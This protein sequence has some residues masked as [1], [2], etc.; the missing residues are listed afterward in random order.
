MTF[1]VLGP[2]EVRRDGE[3]VEIAGQ[4][5]RTLLGLLVLDAGRIVP[6]ER[7][8]AGI[9]DDQVP[10]GVGNALQALISRLRSALGK[11][12]ARG[13]VVGE[14]AGYR[15]V[16]G[17]DQVDVRRFTLLAR[18]GQEALAA[19]DASTAA[20]TLRE[21]LALWRGPVLAGL[22]GEVIAADVARLESR[23]LSVAEDRIEAELRLGRPAGLIDELS[24]LLAAHPLRERLHGQRMRA[25]Y[26]AG[27]RVEALAAY[28][29]A[30]RTFRDELGADPSPALA[31]LHLTMLRG[32]P[33]TTDNG[34][35]PP[36]AE[37]GSG[38]PTPGTRRSSAPGG[39]RKGRT[40]DGPSQVSV[41][42]G[43]MPD[44]GPEVGGRGGREPDGR[45]EGWG[46]EGRAPEGVPPAGGRR[47]NLR[48][49]LTSFVG[50]EADLDHTAG[51]LSAHRLVTLIGP[52]G[53]GKTRLATEVAE[54]VTESMPDGV[55]LAELAPVSD[56]AGLVQSLL[57]ALDLRDGRSLPM[58][59]LPQDPFER[60]IRALRGKRLLIVLDNCEHVVEQA[61][62]IAD[63]VLADCPGVR[64]L[65]TSREPLGITGEV[66]W[67]LPPLG[68]PPA[69]VDPGDAAGYPAVRLFADRAAAVRPG[70][71]V[72]QDAGPVV[73]ICRAL[74][75]LPLAIE[76]AAARLRSL[77]A[78][79]IAARLG[80]R[81]G[82]FRLL[83]SGSRTAQARHQTLRAVV[84]WSWNL[85]DE[86]ERALGRR[87][88]VFAGGA[89]LD[90]I[91]RV[92]AA[93]VERLKGGSADAT[94]HDVLGSLARLVDKSFV[95]FD[96][97]RYRMLETIRAYATERL[98]ESGELDVV[99]RAH[100][101]HFTELAEA[102]EPRLR[103]GEQIDRLAE[104]SAEH[105]NLSTALRWAIESGA[106][107]LALRLVSALGWYWWLRG[108]RLEGALRSREALAVAS[109]GP[110]PMRATNLAIHVLNGVGLL[111]SWE[112]AQVML[113]EMRDLGSPEVAPHPL[114]ALAGPMFVLSGGGAPQSEAL[115][116]EM[117]GHPDPWVVA[118]GMLL[119]GLTHY[120]AG[121]IEQG[122]WE[123]LT[124]LD[125]YRRIGDRWGAATALATLSDV[126]FLRGESELGIAVMRD[127]LELAVELGALE[128]T[129]YMRARLAL[130]LNLL[131][132][133]A[134]AERLLHDI[135]QVAA[136]SGDQLGEAGIMAA[137]GEF[138]RQDGDLRRAREHYARAL[139]MMDASAAVPIQMISAVNSSLGLLA[140]HEGDLAGARRLLT[141]ALKQA[142]EVSDAQLAGIAIIAC[143][144]LALAQRRAEE[145]ATLLGGAETVKGIA[146]VVD[147]DH[148]R[149]TADAKA[150]L[151]DQ[152]FRR[153]LER[154]RGMDQDEV[155]ALA[156]RM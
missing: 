45:A 17:P 20:A 78:G 126:H 13:L 83:S 143:A 21:A 62:R 82:R 125:G 51:L 54:A 134:E 136:D 100:A 88:A 34:S 1:A 141:L 105:E 67:T 94:A 129:A 131:G 24:G 152:A 40:P 145:A 127:A 151:G 135:A 14:P 80:A 123:T 128:D 41:P 12:H 117:A 65:A 43:R 139:S 86:E 71:Q 46:R 29:T 25:L 108:H 70:Y 93:T 95:I 49:R 35:A 58:A 110:A 47:G 109:D 16:A 37:H 19:G 72:R 99:R 8:I 64:I 142:T 9:W 68:L 77:T 66:T 32:A 106:G 52:G 96:A 155:V 42:R 114:V 39:A 147:F 2:L 130:G 63:Q 55:W 30:R 74:D 120:S 76:L 48:A 61:A 36:T 5:L 11:N 122:E 104:L 146:A 44:G 154:G 59:S 60:L 101:V 79:E 69:G 97:G 91:E 153:H 112:E 140:V 111:L 31:E 3:V 137:W 85:L 98:D 116:A 38:R 57:S 10:S 6:V 138:A 115:V 27:R 15:L 22:A 81:E 92:H 102:A 113:E 75:G 89:T 133:R 4:R 156:L 84:E 18:A 149:L 50:R 103:T 121:R 33:P 124:A 23:R 73:A 26:G 148:V 56:E 87:L 53:A 150:A 144:G 132:R 118:T 90:A 107:E 119:R 7:L 28:E